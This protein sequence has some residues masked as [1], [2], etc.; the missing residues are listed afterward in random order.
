MKA[1][2]IA[3][4]DAIKELK[5]IHT[6]LAELGYK[7]HT[8]SNATVF[9]SDNQSAIALAKNLVSH[10]RAKHIDIRHYFIREAIQDNI[11]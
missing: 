9:H 6:F 11:I 8:N 5:W 3:L 7:N 2:Y 1:E 10:A 4:T